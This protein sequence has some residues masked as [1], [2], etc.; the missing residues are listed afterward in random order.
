MN[1]DALQSLAVYVPMDRRHAMAAGRVLPD[2]QQGAALFADISGFTQ[3]TEPLV[4]DR[5]N[6]LLADESS[7][8]P[9]IVF[10]PIDP[11]ADAI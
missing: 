4:R 10:W 8:E 11:Q 9:K 1:D 5:T 6:Y 2:R 3:L 7:I